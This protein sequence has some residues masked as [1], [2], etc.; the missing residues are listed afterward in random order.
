NAGGT[1]VQR[2]APLP[3]QDKN[4]LMLC[5]Y[6]L[7]DENILGWLRHSG[8]GEIC[9]DIPGC[10]LLG[11]VWQGTSNLAD[12]A[13]LNAFLSGL[14]RGEEAA[15]SQMFSMPLPEGALP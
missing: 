15:F 2:D 5:R 1:E 6:A 7:V 13:T 11:L 9:R 10:E 4:A 14:S 3:P 12:P 8:R